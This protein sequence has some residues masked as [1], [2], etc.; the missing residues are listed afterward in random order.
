MGGE[1][2]AVQVR[3][4]LNGM[5]LSHAGASAEVRVF[6]RREAEL[7]ALMPEKAEADTG[8]QRLCR[9]PGLVKAISVRTGQEVKAGEHPDAGVPSGPP[10]VT[11]G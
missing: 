1:A 5:V 11:V 6:T 9:M 8:K 10:V 4:I 2:I 3:P 7:A